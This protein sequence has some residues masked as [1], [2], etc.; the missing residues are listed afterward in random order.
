MN[1][2]GGRPGIAA[3]ILA[4]IAILAAFYWTLSVNILI[5]AAL[6][7]LVALCIVLLA[8]GIVKPYTTG[9]A[10]LSYVMVKSLYFAS[11]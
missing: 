3:G 5:I 8:F 11:L 1:I 6:L 7:L 2:F 4:V 10:E 9:S